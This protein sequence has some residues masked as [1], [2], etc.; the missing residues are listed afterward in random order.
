MAWGLIPGNRASLVL[1][2]GEKDI[3]F[4]T[5]WRFV[6]NVLGSS[7]KSSNSTML[8]HTYFFLISVLLLALPVFRLMRV[9]RILRLFRHFPGL[10]I[11]FYTLRASSA[12]LFFMLVCLSSSMLFFASLI[13]FADDKVMSFSLNQLCLNYLLYG[14]ISFLNCMKHI[15]IF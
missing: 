7:L 9:F 1:F 2:L 13:F 11:M 8:T 10:W 4:H 15:Q 6:Q 3:T 12:D 5:N 14:F